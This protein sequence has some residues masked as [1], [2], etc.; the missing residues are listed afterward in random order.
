MACITL[1][2]SSRKLGLKLNFSKFDSSNDKNNDENNDE[3]Q[4]SE[5]SISTENTFNAI[6]RINHFT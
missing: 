3:K 6:E 4:T 1:A 2:W 5:E